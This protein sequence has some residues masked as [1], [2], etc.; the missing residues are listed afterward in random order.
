M[1]S[2]R[3]RNKM[4][5]RIEFFWSVGFIKS[6]KNGSIMSVSFLLK[7][8][9]RKMMV[10]V[11]RSIGKEGLKIG[12]KRVKMVEIMRKCLVMYVFFMGLLRIRE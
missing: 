7:R 8:L 2:V 5:M 10:D 4:V 9:M 12:V 6:F 3:I 1:G 11:K